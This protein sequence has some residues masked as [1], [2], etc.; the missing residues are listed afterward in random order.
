MSFLNNDNRLETLESF[1]QVELTVPTGY[2]LRY[3]NI[4]YSDMLLPPVK[5]IQNQNKL[6]LEGNINILIQYIIMYEF[7]FNKKFNIIYNT[8]DGLS[9]QEFADLV[10]D[11][12]KNKDI[13]ENILDSKII[14]HKI[15][16]L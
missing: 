5:F 11:N 12:D 1:S 8:I 13:P 15:K 16:G 9:L 3:E 2:N 7:K 14:V 4:D 10:I 6:R